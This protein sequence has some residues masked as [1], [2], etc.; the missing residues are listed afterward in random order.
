MTGDSIATLALLIGLELVLGIDNILVISIM[1]S[2][3]PKEVQQKARMFGLVLAMVARLVLLWVIVTLASMT[4]PLIA[5]F[6]VRDIILLVGGLFLLYKAV[7]EI[8]QTVELKEE[9]H[10]IGGKSVSSQF[11]AAIIQIVFLDI[12]FSVD[13]VLTAVGLTNELWVIITAVVASF[14]V[15]LIF[16]KQVGDFILRNPAL[17]ILALAF[18]VTIGVTIFLEG[19]HQHVQKGYIYLPM[20]FAL[21]IEL[22]QMRYI[23]NRKKRKSI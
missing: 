14:A 17:K 12:V 20:G 8:H 19:M 1:V 5:T 7:S 16:A 22:L 18:L 15:I 10:H 9:G 11:N 2:R 21:G 3:L 13:S 4:T 6:S 23:A